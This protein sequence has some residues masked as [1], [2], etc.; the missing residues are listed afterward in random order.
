MDVVVFNVT[1]HFKFAAF[2][3]NN[4]LHVYFDKT[5]NEGSDTI[6]TRWFR[7]SKGEIPYATFNPT[8][9][10]C[11]L[12]EEHHIIKSVDIEYSD[13]VNNIKDPEA[14]H[15]LIAKKCV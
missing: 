7:N 10:V 13:I 5:N 1:E 15:N 9:I 8:S 4:I 11:E 14:F 6:M 12:D 3:S 2:V